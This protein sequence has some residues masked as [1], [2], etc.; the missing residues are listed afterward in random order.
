MVDSDDERVDLR[1]AIRLLRRADKLMREV[2]GIRAAE[3]E[4]RS[5]SARNAQ[6]TRKLLLIQHMM[7]KVS[8]MVM[9]EYHVFKGDDLHI[10]C[11][12]DDDVP[13]TKR[14]FA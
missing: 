4:G 6:I 1:E 10:L 13:P 5:A 7:N 12:D 8:C 2:N 9:D 14:G 3:L 11:D